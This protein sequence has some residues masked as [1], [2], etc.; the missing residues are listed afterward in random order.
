MI[1]P[2][3]KLLSPTKESDP[4]VLA[5]LPPQLQHRLHL[6]LDHR[7]NR[8]QLFGQPLGRRTNYLVVGTS[9]IVPVVCQ[10]V[11]LLFFFFGTDFGKNLLSDFAWNGEEYWRWGDLCIGLLTYYWGRCLSIGCGRGHD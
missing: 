7:V 3:L 2:D 8:A 9:T 11:V 6:Q 1:M 4:L 5:P 10:D